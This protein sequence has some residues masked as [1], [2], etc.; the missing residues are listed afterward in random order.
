MEREVT[1]RNSIARRLSLIVGGALVA[2]VLVVGAMALL[3]QRRQLTRA[4]E[5]KA[6]TLAQFMAQVSPISVLSLNFVEMNNNVKK[7]VLTDDEAIYAIVVNE[8]GIPLAYYLKE[9]DPAVG[10]EARALWAARNPMAA[11]EAMKNSTNVLQVEAPITAGETGI[12]STMIGFSSERM[13]RALM[14]QIVLIGA[15]LVVVTGATLLLLELALRRI[16]KP[17]KVLTAAATQISTG[18]LDVVL[19][20]L[21]RKDEL[22]VLA[23]AFESMATQLRGLID[24]MEQRMADL[25]RMGQALQKSEEEFRRIVATASEGIWVLGAETK[26]TFVNAR[27]AEM[28]GCGDA[29]MIGRPMTDFMF[30]EDLPDH[31]QKMDNR[32]RGVSENYER[33]FRR[34][35]GQAVWTHVSAT[36]IMEAGRYAGS[37]AMFT[38]ITERKRAEEELGRYRDS[39]E[40]T[41]QQR[42]AELRQARDAAEAANQAKSVFLAN[43][44]HELRTPLNA[45][46]G[47]S[48]MMRSDPQLTDEQ[49]GNLDIINR[50]GEHLLA[51]IN[52]VLEMAKIEAGRLKLEPAP[53]D[54]GSLVHDVADM[55]RLRAQE[56]GLYLKLDQSSEFPRYIRGDEAR[57]R[58]ILVNLVGNAVK[59]TERGG[60]VI[61]LAVKQNDRLH[62]LIE[63]E[64]TGPGIG[65]EDRRRVFKPFVQLAEGAEQKGTGLGLAIT[66]QFVELMGGSVGVESTPG[67]GSVFRADLPVELVADVEIPEP[68]KAQGDVVGLTP[69]QPSFRVLIAEDQHENQLLLNRLM[70]DIGLE[71]R[72]ANNGEECVKIFQEWL[73]DLVWMDRRMPV[74]DGLEATRRIRRLPGGDKVRIVAVTASAFREQQQEMFDA[75]MNDF[76]SKPYRFEEIYE[77]LAR[78]LGLEYVYRSAVAERQ[79]D[80]SVA[81][82][83]ASVALLPSALRQQ[84]GTALEQLDSERISTLL[85]QVTKIN[86]DLG[87]AFCDLAKGFDYA[88]MQRALD[89]AN[90]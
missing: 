42:T 44:S 45:I 7:V 10:E 2:A 72:V 38:D 56:K 19:T 15:V 6:A 65:P 50:S 52:D 41:V 77:C 30:E 13:H 79:A 81:L 43:M 39:L 46:L 68:K 9:A 31:R 63:I 11:V 62:L 47:F 25:Q 75:G 86:A 37:F 83:P 14:L 28:L 29:A 53:F 67:K 16:L 82:A 69:G 78:Q 85:E 73:P 22:G 1:R 70:S 8:K 17:V 90:T 4:L 23:R 84:L 66:K 32:A 80:R 60:V 20:G 59:F 87:A 18:D 49:T 76:V 71:T 55:M 64:D 33:R 54:L 12:G 5:T 88:A 74:M 3:E 48:R 26:T 89:A 40:E 61:R 57:I 21:H 35:D 58:Q 51:L 34:S 36:P 24:G 27:M